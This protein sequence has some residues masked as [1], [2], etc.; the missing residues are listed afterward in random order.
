MLGFVIGCIF[1]GTVGMT[2]T[3]LCVAAKQA[4]R[5]LEEEQCE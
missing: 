4:D 1:G 2:A 5:Y 3:C